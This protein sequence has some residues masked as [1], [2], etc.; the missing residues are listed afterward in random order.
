VL[1]ARVGSRPCWGRPRTVRGLRLAF[2]RTGVVASLLVA[3]VARAAVLRDSRDTDD[4]ARIRAASPH[5]ADVFERAEAAA[6]AGDPVSATDLFTE[7]VREAP[8][9]PLI[10][11][12]QCEA[13]AVLGKREEALAA[14]LRGWTATLSPRGASPTVLRATVRALLSGPDSVVLKPENVGRAYAAADE[15]RKK[16]PSE[17]WGYAAMC[18]IAVR[19]GDDVMLQHCL[20]DLERLDPNHAETQSARAAASRL[21]PDWW[22][23]GGWLLIVAAFV[24]T[25]VKALRQAMRR[26]RNPSSLAAAVA[27]SLATTAIAPPAHAKPSDE[28]PDRVS[29][30]KVND[31]DPESSVPSV[32]AA[33]KNPLEMGYWLMDVIAKGQEAIKRGDHEAA[34]RYF[35][36]ITKAVPNRGV[37]FQKLCAEYEATGD[38][39]NAIAACAV[40]LPLPGSLVSDYTHYVDLVLR[41]PGALTPTDV[42]GLAAALKR[43]R[44]SDAGREAADVPECQVGIRVFSGELLEE[45][46]PG[47]ATRAPE[48]PLTV[49][50]QWAL[51]VAHGDWAAAN[52]AIAHAKAIS[53]PPEVTNE[54]LR[55]TA[56]KQAKGRRSLWMGVSFVVLFV[57]A[58]GALFVIWQEHL[59]SLA[60]ASPE[61]LDAAEAEDEG[62][63]EGEKARELLREDDKTAAVAPAPDALAATD[64]ASATPR[65][66]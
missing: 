56:A 66:V 37:G 43:L 31:K 41:K 1:V 16:Y 63:A 64:T 45:C 4:L 60:T 65:D 25:I 8:R 59:K 40:V 7:A 5:A 38:L 33:N 36:A 3:H 42:A 12:R 17:L 51:A 26:C 28:H 48:D 47:L 21:R 49:R 58:L 29:D 57:I 19:I 24:T 18:D 13:M 53:I 46:V 20:G 52:Q 30:W 50:A 44:S 23:W 2:A 22:I 32:E 27:L 35:R 39:E 14:C 6:I 62:P 61:G 54:M 34:I 11:R 55:D 10:L 15:A 9:S